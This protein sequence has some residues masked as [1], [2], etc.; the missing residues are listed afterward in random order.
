MQFRRTPAS[1]AIYS[2]ISILFGIKGIKYFVKYGLRKYS[3]FRSMKKFTALKFHQNEIFVIV[4]ETNYEKFF[5]I[6]VS[7]NNE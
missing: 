4:I 7:C 3:I 6:V 1:I 5:V 2:N